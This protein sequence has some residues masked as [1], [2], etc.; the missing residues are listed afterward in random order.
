MYPKTHAK[1]LEVLNISIL[2]LSIVLFIALGVS[3]LLSMAAIFLSLFILW[4]FTILL[5]IFSWSI[6]IRCPNPTCNGQ[7]SRIN[8]Q[9]SAFRVQLNYQCKICNQIYTTRIYQTPQGIQIRDDI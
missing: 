3:I 5:T 2:V 6:S 4:V 9:V 8:K 1:L 7:M